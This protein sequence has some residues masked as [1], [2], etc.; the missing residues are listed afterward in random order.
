MKETIRTA[1]KEHIC[2][3]CNGIIYTGNK[4]LEIKTR[5]PRADD[6]DQVG[7]EYYLHREHLNNSCKGRLQ[8]MTPDE[9]RNV[10]TKCNKG[11]HSFVEHTEFDH[12]AGCYQ[13]D[14]PTGESSCENCGIKET[15]A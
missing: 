7:I 9:Y 10:I 1:R 8:F 13:V 14:I 15:K 2:G 11:N 12:Y 3:W 4:Y 5:L 6:D